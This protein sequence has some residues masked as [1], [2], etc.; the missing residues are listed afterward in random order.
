MLSSSSIFIVAS[1]EFLLVL[2]EVLFQETK[3]IV[4][5]FL[6]NNYFCS[7]LVKTNTI[8]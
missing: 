6:D 1:S 5:F 3:T 2:N 7:W 8:R 4:F